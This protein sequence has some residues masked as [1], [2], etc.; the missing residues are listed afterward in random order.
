MQP[1]KTE[2]ANL[3]KTHMK[4]LSAMSEVLGGVLITSADGAVAVIGAEGSKRKTIFRTSFVSDDVN[5]NL[6]AQIVVQDLL[7]EEGIEAIS[8]FDFN[9]AIGAH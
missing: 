3:I 8:E 4:E 5:K 6:D 7:E 9:E 1:F 2:A